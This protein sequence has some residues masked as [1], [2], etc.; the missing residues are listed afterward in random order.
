MNPGRL[1]A[2]ESKTHI[3]TVWTLET[4][5]S[6]EKRERERGRGLG[7]R[8]GLKVGWVERVDMGGAWE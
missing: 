7:K 1:I 5:L 4:G 6:G 2:L 8:K 3:K